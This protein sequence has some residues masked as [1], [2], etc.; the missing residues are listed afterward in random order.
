[1]SDYN[2]EERRIVHTCL[3]EGD[4][5][6]LKEWKNDMKKVMWLVISA[7]GIGLINLALSMFR[8]SIKLGG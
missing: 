6:V 3:H 1:M 2:G 8:V 4:I 7:L 5:A